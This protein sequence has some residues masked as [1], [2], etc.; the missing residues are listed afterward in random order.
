LTDGQYNAQEGCFETAQG[1]PKCYVASDHI[2]SETYRAFTSQHLFDIVSND[3]LHYNHATQS[4]VMMHIITGV[5]ESGRV[6]ITAIGDSPQEAKELYQRFIE[7]L[8]REAAKLLMK[9]A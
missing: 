6:G 8:D 5:G 4:G 3:H 2:E 7:V 9:D 1:H